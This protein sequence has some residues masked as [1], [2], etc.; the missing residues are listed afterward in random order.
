MQWIESSDFGGNLKI[1][2][3]HLYSLAFRVVLT[4]DL[5]AMAYYYF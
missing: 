5:I 2:E 4:N 1:G 3:Q